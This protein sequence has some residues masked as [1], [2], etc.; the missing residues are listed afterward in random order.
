[1]VPNLWTTSSPQGPE[2]W[3]TKSQGQKDS[4][5]SLSAP[6]QASAPHKLMKYLPWV[7]IHGHLPSLPVCKIAIYSSLVQ[8]AAWKA[9]VAK[10]LPPPANGAG[11]REAPLLFLASRG[12]FRSLPSHELQEVAEEGK[13]PFATSTSGGASLRC[14]CWRLILAMKAASA[15]PL[16]S[17]TS[18]Q[19]GSTP[20]FPPHSSW[21]GGWQMQRLPSPPTQVEEHGSLSWAL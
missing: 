3:F 1:M 2:T 7:V 4:F 15:T 20:Y 17:P 21:R 9:W 19:L 11:R 5:P 14:L 8:I 12:S 10:P 16:P 13:I 18:L 6:L